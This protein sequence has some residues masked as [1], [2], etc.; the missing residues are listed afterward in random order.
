VGE[1]RTYFSDTFKQVKA[2]RHKDS[3][4]FDKLLSDRELTVLTHIGA[5]QDDGEIARLL[6][7][8]TATVEKHRFNILGKLGLD[9]TKELVRYARDHGFTLP[10]S[11]DRAMLP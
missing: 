7:L 6:N 11:S 9:G 10:S 2:A 8:S 3:R 5:G 4:S 1:G